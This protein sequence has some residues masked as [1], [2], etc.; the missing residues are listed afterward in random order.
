MVVGTCTE[1][2]PLFLGTSKDLMEWSSCLQDDDL[3]VEVTYLM[4]SSWLSMLYIIP[5]SILVERDKGMEASSIF[6]MLTALSNNFSPKVYLA[7]EAFL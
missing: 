5:T 6:M 3:T 1:G 4:R 2:I 7:P